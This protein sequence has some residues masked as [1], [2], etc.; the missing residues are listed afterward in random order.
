MF[1]N[2]FEM[3]QAY[4]ILTDSTFMGLSPL[5]F[6]YLIKM[7][8]CF[9]PTIHLNRMN[10]KEFLFYVSACISSASKMA[11]L[12]AIFCVFRGESNNFWKE[13]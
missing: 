10:S 4:I 1:G 8:Y 11:I 3:L 13:N 5:H 6:H 12:K 2:H 7:P 9:C